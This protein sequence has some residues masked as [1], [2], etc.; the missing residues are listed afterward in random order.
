M[1]AKSLGE[2]I[3]LVEES[4]GKE[5]VGRSYIG[6]TKSDAIIDNLLPFFFPLAN[7][8][9]LY[10]HSARWVPS[11]ELKSI[12]SDGEVNY[13]ET[14]KGI[15]FDAYDFVYGNKGRQHFF[16]TLLTLEDRLSF[17]R[18]K[19][20]NIKI[21]LIDSNGEEV[22]EEKYARLPMIAKE[23]NLMPFS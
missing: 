10:N 6:P 21:K 11:I 20:P 14:F 8:P 9:E 12:F 13:Q 4:C 23:H 1:N 22:S 2:F 19:L 7:G 18:R 5:I 15:S 16:R 3:S 17:I